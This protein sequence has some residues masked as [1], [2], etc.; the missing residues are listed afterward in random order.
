M[1]Y[2]HGQRV[3]RD[4]YS[5]HEIKETTDSYEIWIE[6]EINEV[7]RWKKISKTTPH[8]LEYNINLE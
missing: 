2:I 8:T 5:I 7:L 6:N 4:T 1:N 3:L